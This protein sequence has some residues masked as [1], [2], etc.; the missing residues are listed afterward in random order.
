MPVYSSIHILQAQLA[1]VPLDEIPA[2]NFIQYSFS[3]SN[4]YPNLHTSAGGGSIEI[5]TTGLHFPLG[6]E[7]PIN[8]E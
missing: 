4:T 7:V 6:Y 5:P 1:A 3:S 8:P 2:R